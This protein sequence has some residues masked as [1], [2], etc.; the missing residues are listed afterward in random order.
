[1]VFDGDERVYFVAETK[2]TNDIND[3]SL[4][5]GERARILAGKGHF[6]A[7]DVPYA[8][9]VNSLSMALRVL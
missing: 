1:M 2:G 4:R 3:E 5:G 7:I 8:A 9:P 6:A